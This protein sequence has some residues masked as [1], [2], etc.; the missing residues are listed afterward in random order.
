MLTTL[1][2]LLS[3]AHAGVPV[4]PST[5]KANIDW[6]TSNPHAVA[7]LQRLYD[8]DVAG[9][10]STGFDMIKS[11]TYRG[12][13]TCGPAF[14]SG[15]DWLKAPKAS[16]S[17]ADETPTWLDA[18]LTGWSRA[19]LAGV[20]GIPG[21]PLTEVYA[22]IKA[23]TIKTQGGLPELE[24]VTYE[25]V[26]NLILDHHQSQQMYR[27]VDETVFA[28]RSVDMLGKEA[29]VSPGFFTSAW[30]ADAKKAAERKA[31]KLAEEAAKAPAVV[32]QP[33]APPAAPD[34]E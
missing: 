16:K 13:V 30:R 17:A 19:A 7:V 11:F 21:Q 8:N 24:S 18:L 28:G 6:F 22:A 31:A 14:Y 27:G 5:L 26:M 1:Y 3:A 20:K 23:G 29:S 10:G 32:V 15:F 12:M 34:A 4:E 25:T 2:L 9:P 33:A